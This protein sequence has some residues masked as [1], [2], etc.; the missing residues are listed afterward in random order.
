MR[1]YTVV[2]DFDPE[3]RIYNVSVPALPGCYAWGATRAQALR[4]IREV[5]SV[6]LQS[7]QDFG[8]PIPEEVDT[9]RVRVP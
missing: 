3:D 8:D 2:I 5:A 6:F 9:E 1:V 4:R 7:M